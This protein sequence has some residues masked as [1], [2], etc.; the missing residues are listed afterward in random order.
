M[1]RPALPLLATQAV[2]SAAWYGATRLWGQLLS[3]GVTILLARLLVPADYGLFAIALSVLGVLELLQE[4][5]LG[6]AIVQ[7]QTLTRQ[8]INAVFW[9]V[10][11]T[12][13]LLTGATFLA[14]GVI[15]HIY[16]DPRLGGT[17]R[18]LC[19]TFL[20][21]SLGMV[22]YS[23][24][25]KAVDLRRR[26]LAE[27]LGAAASALVALTLA[28]LGY[29]V[30][31]L[32]LGHLARAVVLNTALYL[33]SK[34]LPGLD[35]AFDE[36]GAILAFGLRIAGSHLTGS[37]AGAL[38]TFILARFL[39]GTAVG[40]YSMAQ[41][42]TE[43]PHRLS[44][45]IINQVSLPVF[46]KLQHDHRLLSA[47]FLKIS[48]YLAVVSFPLQAGL[49]LVAPDLVPVL[50]SPKWE[51]MV[52]PFQI[53]CLESV[54][55]LSTLTCSPLLTARGRA[56][57]LFNRSFLG[58]VWLAGSALI[59]APYGLVGVATARLITIIP[60]RLTLLFPTLAELGLSLPAYV[61]GLGS[62]LGASAIMT[63]VVLVA[64]HMW[65]LPGGHLESLVMSVTAGA[66]TYSAALF[67]LDRSFASEITSVA[68]GLRSTSEG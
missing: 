9:V 16:A 46:S 15:G 32:V 52:V 44:T 18:V 43:A 48:K 57:L 3:W 66:A 36:M 53:F 49:I 19:L 17:L 45:A 12:S 6:T 26:S 56:E 68:R 37:S 34:W 54:V 30:W 21:N 47:Y 22:P 10:A 35:V 62:P 58:F 4:F 60:I 65:T 50:L 64:R 24:L 8:Q 67:L 55:I 23:L 29:G 41:S 51:A 31:A 33:L 61:R 20:L 38:S 13:L 5:G 28:Y 63:G 25:T 1:T 14:A 59:G 11:A 39:G 7:R 27:A 42:L 40:L 2:K